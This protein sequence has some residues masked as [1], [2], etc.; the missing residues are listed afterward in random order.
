M[1]ICFYFIEILL[2]NY[3]RC[4]AVPQKQPE[5]GR[6]ALCEEEL[7]KRL[8]EDSDVQGDEGLVV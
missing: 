2:F 6:G 1:I 3:N 5:P 8:E 7:Q 4:H